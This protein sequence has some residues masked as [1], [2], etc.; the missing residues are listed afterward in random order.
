MD[1]TLQDVR[2]GPFMQP[3]SPNEAFAYI[4]KTTLGVPLAEDK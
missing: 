1:F 4:G 2:A 3:F